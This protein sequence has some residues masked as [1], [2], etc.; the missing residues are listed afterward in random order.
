MFTTSS[1]V[2]LGS[3]FLLG[4]A[5]SPACPDEHARPP[6]FADRF[7]GE[8]DRPRTGERIAFL[9]SFEQ[10]RAEAK[11][12]G[13]RI[14]VYFTGPGCPW[15]RVLEART[16]RDAKVVELSKK[17][18]CVK[19]ITDRDTRL[20]DEFHIDTIPRS[21]LLLA[22]GTVLDQRV[23][24]WPATA[25]AAWLEAGLIRSS[26]GDIKTGAPPPPA[27]GFPEAEANLNLWFVDNDRVTATWRE[28]GAFRHPVL[29][30]FLGL[31]GFKPRIEHLSRADFP[32]RWKHAEA[33]HRSPDLLA[34]TNWAGMIRELDGAGRYRAVVSE[35]LTFKTE[36]AS[37]QDF[38]H[39]FLWLVRGSAHESNARKAIGAILGPGSELELPGPPLPIESGHDEAVETARRAVVAYLSGDPSRLKSIASARSS[40]LAECTRPG[41]W[42]SGTKVVADAV[43][44]RGN[45]AIAVAVVEAR[46]END[47]LVGADPVVVVLVREHGRWK[48][49]VVSRSV[50]TL[51]EN[52]PRLC[53]LLACAGPSSSGPPEPRLRMPRDGQ[54]V[55]EDR[56][57]LVWDIPG[58]RGAL[59][60]HV[61]EQRCGPTH[62]EGTSW[63]EAQLAVFPAE[64]RS[65]KVNVFSGVI[66]KGISWCVW[67][68]GR[69]GRVA[70]SPTAH[71][72]VEFP[73]AR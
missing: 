56:P 40:Q 58:E 72:T 39:R 73:R 61:C 11:S 13:R 30:Q 17:F 2:A 10:A 69:D 53:G 12:A 1:R 67:T 32:T 36:S 48:A 42:Y 54:V 9:A 44:L 7:K 23:G 68:V 5:Q 51:K 31:L 65:G 27:V 60:A 3:I 45:D 52:V 26:S 28:P 20:A 38:D 4:L 18:I 35:R 21:L 55:N 57:D 29:L 33:L 64:P 14:L 47:R 70:V 25:Y 71:F 34:A 16:F 59:L 37:C 15:C 62:E 50:A 43:E 66:G 49:L 8:P 22:D 41:P 19:L 6:K 24:Y 63:P 46:F